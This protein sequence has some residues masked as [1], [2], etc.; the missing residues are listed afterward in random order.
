M[1]G[2]VGGS[3]RPGYV[4]RF[5]G[6]VAIELRGFVR[7]EVKADLVRLTGTLSDLTGLEFYVGDKRLSSH[8]GIVIE[9]TSYADMQS[10]YGQGGPLCFCRNWGNGGTLHSARIEI[11]D[12]YADCLAHELMHAI[13]FDNHWTGPDATDARPSALARRYAPARTSDFSAWDRKAIEM[14]YDE[15]LKPGTPRQSALSLAETILAE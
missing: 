15:R 14:L 12:E 6:P 11:S 13:G 3:D 4:R 1:R 7:P 10:R 8:G 2:T 9:V 5:D